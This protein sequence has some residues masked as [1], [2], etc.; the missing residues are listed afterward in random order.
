MESKE[1]MSPFFSIIIPAY[2]AQEVYLR[3]CI[4][5]LVQQ[6]FEDIEI[7]I[8]DDGSKKEYSDCYDIIASEDNRIKV[9]HQDNQGVSAARNHG[10]ESASADWIMFVDSDDWI[11]LNAC[12]V[13][14]ETLI[15]HPCD[16]LLFDHISEYANGTSNKRNAGL[17]D[18]TLYDFDNIKT[19]EMFYRRAM[20]TPNLNNENFSIIYY[21]VD[22]VYSRSFLNR[23]NVR[24]PVGLPKSEDKVF[25]LQCLEKIHTLYYISIP[26]YHYRINE[27]SAS[28]RYSENVDKERRDLSKY[29]EI[30]AK[31]MDVELGHL[32]NNPSY[33]VLYE[34]Y[35][36]FV[37]GIISDVMFSKYYHKDYPR[38]NSQRREEVK[39][40]LESEPF[41]TAIKDTK[42]CD[43]GWEA[44]IKKFMLSHGMTSLFCQLRKAK[45]KV[46]RTIGGMK[47]PHCSTEV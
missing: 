17:I 40:F 26:F 13:I 12:E 5:S 44:K 32:T 41:K 31:E 9:I 21:S 46:I 34:D 3:E 22:K 42:Y 45:K 38:T 20:G 14:H 11:E 23:E 16:I 27:Q 47:K 30:I 24:F 25:I 35:I 36:R 43:L 10:I 18:N 33:S 1:A 4:K 28:N 29:L 19:K 8:V 2:N 37:F 6:T 39:Q 7:I 15:K